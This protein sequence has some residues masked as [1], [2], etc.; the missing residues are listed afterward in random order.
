MTQDT[1]ELFKQCI[2]DTSINRELDKYHACKTS[3]DLLPT[4]VYISQ[5]F[6]KIEGM[7]SAGFCFPGGEGVSED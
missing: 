1:A 3:N 4:G 6:P 2:G 5:I 7:G